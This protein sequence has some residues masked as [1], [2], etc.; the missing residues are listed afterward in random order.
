MLD[1]RNIVMNN[2][3]LINKAHMVEFAVV[4]Q[5]FQHITSFVLDLTYIKMIRRFQS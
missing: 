4:T 2:I 1:L 3:I 5:I